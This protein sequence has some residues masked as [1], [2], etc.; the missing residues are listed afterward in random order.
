MMIT[1]L[2]TTITCSM[3]VFNS[4]WNFIVGSFSL[5]FS[6]FR[7]LQ[8]HSSIQRNEFFAWKKQGILLG[9]INFIWVCLFENPVQWIK[10]ST[11]SGK[12]V[13]NDFF[14]SWIFLSTIP[15]Y[16]SVLHSINYRCEMNQYCRHYDRTTFSA[17]IKF[18]FQ[19]LNREFLAFNC[20]LYHLFERKL[21][22][23]WKINYKYD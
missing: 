10:K 4:Q 17:R 23:I 7:K 15:C 11:K 9:F 20:K 6:F 21:R 12:F 3:T 2:S 5:M 16:F 1:Q 8:F 14:F 13:E 22:M 18:I 19:V